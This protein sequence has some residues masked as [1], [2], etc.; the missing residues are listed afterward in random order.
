MPADRARRVAALVKQNVAAILLAEFNRP[1]M[2]WITITDC[3]MSRDL[4]RADLYFSTIEQNLAHGKALEILASEKG[5]IKRELAARIV[6]KY[7]PD[8]NFI[9]DDTVLIDEK[10]REIHNERQPGT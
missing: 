9:W 7:L 2:Q 3:V 5:T 4:K 8:L 6:I 10:I 1:E